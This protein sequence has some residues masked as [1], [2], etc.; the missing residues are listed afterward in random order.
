MK[1]LAASIILSAVLW[2]VATDIVHGLA[3]RAIAADM[4]LGLAVS[5]VAI[6]MAIERLGWPVRFAAGA[7]FAAALG[8][9]LY[10]R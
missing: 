7:A 4:A 10:A 2:L 3:A 9:A 1:E 5:I 8:L 6:A